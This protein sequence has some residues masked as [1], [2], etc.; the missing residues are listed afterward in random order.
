MRVKGDANGNLPIHI[1]AKVSYANDLNL[2]VWP[3][4]PIQIRFSNNWVSAPRTK[5]KK[6]SAKR[7]LKIIY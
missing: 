7:A 5:K 3:G 6:K 1:A 4:F 2:E